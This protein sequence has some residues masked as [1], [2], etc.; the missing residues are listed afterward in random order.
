MIFRS[1]KRKRAPELQAYLD[2]NRKGSSGKHIVIDTE[3]TSLDKRSAR[4]LSFGHVLIDGRSIE[5]STTGELFLEHDDSVIDASAEIHQITGIAEH[6]LT[7][8]N[9]A[10]ELLRIL[11]NHTIVAHVADFD[12]MLINQL[13]SEIYG[14]KLRNKVE[15]TFRMAVFKEYGAQP[16]HIE[17]DRFTL[18]ALIEKYH[19]P[20]TGRHT[21]LGD[22]YMTAMLYLYLRTK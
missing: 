4:M 22:A 10:A 14:I 21:A 8:Q 20:V 19:I 2:L 6:A 15:D 13:L 12:I 18:D 11:A 5:L 1:F 16:V 9:F 17:K 3:A 7:H